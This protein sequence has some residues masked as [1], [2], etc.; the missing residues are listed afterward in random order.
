[1]FSLR[2]C[3]LPQ[4]AGRE[5]VGL[6]GKSGSVHFRK[7]PAKTGH[8]TDPIVHSTSGLYVLWSRPFTSTCRLCRISE[9]VESCGAFSSF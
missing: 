4:A 3:S 9:V 2:A 5:G 7:P 8:A 6:P 1:M